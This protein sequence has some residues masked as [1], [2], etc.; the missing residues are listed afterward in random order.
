VA[1]QLDIGRTIMPKPAL[2]SARKA[3]LVDRKGAYGRVQV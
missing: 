3:A 2:L 1:R